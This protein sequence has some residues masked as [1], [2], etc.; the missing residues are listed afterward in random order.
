[1]IKNSKIEVVTSGCFITKDK[2]Y[3]AKNAIP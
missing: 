3:L 1:M 2:K